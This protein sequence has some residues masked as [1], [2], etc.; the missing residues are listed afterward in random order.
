MQSDA[1]VPALEVFFE[2]IYKNFFKGFSVSVRFGSKAVIAR[3]SENEHTKKHV[4]KVRYAVFFT[5]NWDI[6]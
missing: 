4:K 1:Y 5:S 2:K 3:V 6:K